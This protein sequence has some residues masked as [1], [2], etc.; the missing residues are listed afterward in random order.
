MVHTRVRN[1]GSACAHGDGN[2]GPAWSTP[3]RERWLCQRLI[4]RCRAVAQVRLCPCDLP[5][6]PLC[7]LL[8]SAHQRLLRRRDIELEENHITILHDRHY[9]YSACATARHRSV[10]RMFCVGPH[11]G[12]HVVSVAMILARLRWE[13]RPTLPCSNWMSRGFQARE[14]HLPR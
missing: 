11:R 3:K 7:L 10:T 8:A 9:R 12:L 14:I 2:K 5:L 4:S 6:L 1:D 13:N